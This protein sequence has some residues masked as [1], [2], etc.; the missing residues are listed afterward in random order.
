[1]EGHGRISP[2]AEIW[3]GHNLPQLAATGR[4]NPDPD[5]CHGVHPRRSLKIGVAEVLVSAALPVPRPLF[6]AHPRRVL[7]LLWI[8]QILHISCHEIE[9]KKEEDKATLK[10]V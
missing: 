7:H 3:E 6:D 10:W 5:C 2:F 8:V 9:A 4:H 1:M